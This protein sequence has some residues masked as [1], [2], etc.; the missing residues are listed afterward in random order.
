MGKAKTKKTFRFSEKA[1]ANLDEYAKQINKS[2]SF[3][4]N[5]ILEDLD[6]Q[7]KHSEGEKTPS[8]PFDYEGWYSDCEFGTYLKAKKKVHCR[9][10][11]PSIKKWL[12]KDRLVDPQICDNCFTKIQEIQG[13]I[14]TQRKEKKTS[15][16]EGEFF[17]NEFGQR[18]PY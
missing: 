13:F 5:K 9:C 17:T 11:Y 10:T 6:T 7:L 3:S 14:D 12:P 8:Q 4:L 18:I 16:H 2:M 1:L 15:N